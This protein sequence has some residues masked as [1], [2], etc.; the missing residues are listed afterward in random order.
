MYVTPFFLLFDFDF[1]TVSPW[2]FTDPFVGWSVSPDVQPSCRIFNRVQLLLQAG[3]SLK[4]VANCSNTGFQ[5]PVSFSHSI[6][7][8]S[9][10]LALN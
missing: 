5:N 7:R 3:K 9:A 8:V 4:P 2:N 1:Y 10:F 6:A